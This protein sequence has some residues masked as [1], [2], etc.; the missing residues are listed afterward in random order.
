MF[1]LS[2]CF[3]QRGVASGSPSNASLASTSMGG[4]GAG[5]S[6]LA[7]STTPRLLPEGRL[8]LQRVSGFELVDAEGETSESSGPSVNPLDLSPDGASV[9]AEAS[10][11]LVAVDV[12]TGRR[13]LLVQPPAGNPLEP[14]A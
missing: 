4:A 13:S 8:L 9:L 3:T 11:A 12:A 2:G 7:P 5:S 1:A 14:F 10:G 6:S